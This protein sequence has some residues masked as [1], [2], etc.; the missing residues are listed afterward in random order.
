MEDTSQRR[1]PCPSTKNGGVFAA[2]STDGRFLYYSKFE[3]SGIWK[4]PLNGGEEPAFWN[5]LQ[6]MLGG[7]GHLPGTGFTFRRL[8]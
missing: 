5:N 1:P 7:T 6:G 3:A 2:E 8:A 4:M